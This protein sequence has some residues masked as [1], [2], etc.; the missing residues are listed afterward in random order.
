MDKHHDKHY[1]FNLSF[2][3]FW[4][5]NTFFSISKSFFMKCTQPWHEL[6]FCF[7]FPLL[8]TT[9][10]CKTLPFTQ[11][12]QFFWLFIVKILFPCESFFLLSL[13]LRRSIIGQ[14]L[15][16]QN[17]ISYLTSKTSKLKTSFDWRL[18]FCRQVWT[19]SRR[20]WVISRE[21]LRWWG[22]PAGSSKPAGCPFRAA[23]P[24]ARTHL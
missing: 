6:S 13:S 16:R 3:F 23:W 18:F 1:P 17:S 10:V 14:S 22:S 21:E 19:L 15:R 12:S 24:P 5:K 7:V 11:K 2:V 9:P 20:W 8:D 4:Q